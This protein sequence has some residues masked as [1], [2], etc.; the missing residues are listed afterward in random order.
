MVMIFVC[1]L[2]ILAGGVMGF[3]DDMAKVNNNIQVVKEGIFN[4]DGWSVLEGTVK[5]EWVW[6]QKNPEA[7]QRYLQEKQQQQH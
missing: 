6:S 5:N 4:Q 2:G 3:R 7:Y 1:S